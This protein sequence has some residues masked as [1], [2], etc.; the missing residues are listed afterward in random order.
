MTV[1]DSVGWLEFFSGGPLAKSYEKHLQPISE[2]VAPT[3]VLYEVYKI[4][5][6]EKGEKEATAAAVQMQ[7]GR[8]VLLT[9][10]I[11]ISAADLSLE[12]QLSM[13]DAIVYATTLQEGAKLVTS[14]KELKDLPQVVYY[15]RSS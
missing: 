1:V 4:M 15:P 12:H 5:K 6:R 13:A 7:R 2:V 10:G 8:V 3:I 14:D 9:E 11:S